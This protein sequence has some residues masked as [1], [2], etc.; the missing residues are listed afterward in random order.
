MPDVGMGTGE[1]STAHATCNIQSACAADLARGSEHGRTSVRLDPKGMSDGRE[2]RRSTARW[3]SST[4][5]TVAASATAFSGVCFSKAHVT[6]SC[7]DHG[8]VGSALSCAQG[9]RMPASHG[10]SELVYKLA[11]P[12]C[13]TERK[14]G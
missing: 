2:T 1:A 7:A 12:L 14:C 9:R 4:K 6:C 11:A 10:R 5:G 8:A 13:A 3:H